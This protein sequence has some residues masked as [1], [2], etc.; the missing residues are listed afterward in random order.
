MDRLSAGRCYLSRSLLGLFPHLARSVRG[1]GVGAFASLVY[2]A[3]PGVFDLFS[4]GNYTNLFGQS[5]LNITLLGGL[6]Y[7]AGKGA[8]ALWHP[9]SCCLDLA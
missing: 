4:A 9:F 7:L 2:L 1:V 8:Q 3:L 6:V 5:I